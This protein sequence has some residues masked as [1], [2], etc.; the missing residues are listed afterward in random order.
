MRRAGCGSIVVAGPDTR[1]VVFLCVWTVVQ[2]ASSNIRVNCIAAGPMSTLAAR[3]I[4]G[5]TDMIQRAQSNVPLPTPG[6]QSDVGD[7]A[8]FLASD[9]AASVTGQ[10]L[11]A[12][13]G[14]RLTQQ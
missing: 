10:V 13:C 2:G 14:W 11:H 4:P 6:T 1:L 8:T 12:D 3:G 7:V 9:A 5:I